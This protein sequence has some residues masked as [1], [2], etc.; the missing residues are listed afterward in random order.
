MAKVTVATLTERLDNAG[1]IIKAMEARMVALEA[2]DTKTRKQLWY[3]Q[4]IAK[5]DFAIGSQ[6]TEDKVIEAEDLS[7]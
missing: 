2:Q 5:G 1:R 6:A 3:L 4:K 7:F